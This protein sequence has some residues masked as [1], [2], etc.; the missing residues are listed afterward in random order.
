[1]KLV[2]LD[3]IGVHTVQITFLS[4]LGKVVDSLTKKL[5]VFQALKISGVPWFLF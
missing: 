1:M 2:Y 4:Y 3:L 5:K